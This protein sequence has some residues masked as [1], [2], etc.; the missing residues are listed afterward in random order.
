MRDWLYVEDHADA[1]LLVVEKGERWGAV[2]QY[3]RQQRTDG[4][5]DLV[6]TTLR[7]SGRTLRPEAERR[8]DRS[9]QF[10]RPIVRAMTLR[11]A[12][13]ASTRIR[14]ELGWQPSVTVEEG[15]AAHRRL[16]SRQ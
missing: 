1:L 9:D 3:R 12:I 2:L 14:D 13:D 5:I 4:I 6:R 8:Y 11:Y 15:L 16:V 7:A 10:R